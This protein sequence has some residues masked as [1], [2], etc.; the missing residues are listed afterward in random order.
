M[1][2]LLLRAACLR[3]C[4]H[5]LVGPVVAWNNE[6]E[7]RRQSPLG[8]MVVDAGQPLRHPEM[9]ALGR[10]LMERRNE[11]VEGMV[12]RIRAEIEFYR[13]TV[14]GSEP[15]RFMHQ[16]CG[17]PAG[18]DRLVDDEDVIHFAGNPVGLPGPPIFERKAVL[19]DASQSGV[20]IGNDLLSTDDEYHVTRSGSDRTEL[21][22]ARGRNKK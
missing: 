12:E 19:V 22:P 8:A 15:K 13:R 4:P 21:A 1:D 18:G 20:E 16:D 17:D 3:L 10:W 9:I 6:R 11:V 14:P 2:H 5:V 7:L